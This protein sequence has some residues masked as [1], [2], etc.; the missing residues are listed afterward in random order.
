MLQMQPS[1]K[2]RRL[3]ALCPP[4]QHEAFLRLAD[5]T[6]ESA[7]MILRGLITEALDRARRG[8][9]IVR[10]LMADAPAVTEG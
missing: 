5:S 6:G 1:R 4:E 8:E 3:V 7:G 2:S 10:G 9:P